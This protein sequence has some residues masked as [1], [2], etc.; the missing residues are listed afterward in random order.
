MELFLLLSIGL[1]IV[2]FISIAL[3][4]APPIPS[5]NN[6]NQP[7]AAPRSDEYVFVHAGLEPT[8][9]MDSVLQNPDS[10]NSLKLNDQLISQ[11]MTQV[12]PRHMADSPE[13]A[14]HR[15][16]MLTASE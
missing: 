3:N 9:P 14:Q 16:L 15:S 10:M 1:S 13:H 11:G 12:N 5:V 2:A 6:Q 8:F 4:Q 7:E